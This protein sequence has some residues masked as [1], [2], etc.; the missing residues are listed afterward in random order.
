MRA[1]VTRNLASSFTRG[2]ERAGR[3]REARPKRHVK[4][5]DGQG[6]GAA[7]PLSSHSFTSTSMPSPMSATSETSYGTRVF[8]SVT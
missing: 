5:R 4:V 1:T 2:A 8:G 3:K 7:P 6:A